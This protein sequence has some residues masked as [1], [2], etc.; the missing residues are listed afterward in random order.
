MHRARHHVRGTAD[1]HR[2][3]TALA[4]AAV[5]L[6]TAPASAQALPPLDRAVGEVCFST[7]PGYAGASWCYRPPGYTDVPERLHNNAASFE[8]N[9]DVTVYAIA[10][11][12]PGQCL[13]RTIWSGDRSPNWEWRN[14]LD[15]VQSDRPTDCQP[16]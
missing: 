6:S 14:K 7:E 4:I 2:R 9:A 10:W 12:G 15:A 3:T 5:F 16:G 8:S 1:M 13:Y 11:V